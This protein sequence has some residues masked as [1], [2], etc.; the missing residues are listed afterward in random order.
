MKTVSD[1][2][3]F[4]FG[5]DTVRVDFTTTFRPSNA[6]EFIFRISRGSIATV[7]KAEV[8]V[9]AVAHMTPRELADFLLR[10]NRRS[11]LFSYVPTD[12]YP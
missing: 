7:F 9:D 6:R 3:P 2:T 1:P 10:L 4:A 11:A 12:E 5:K 8:P